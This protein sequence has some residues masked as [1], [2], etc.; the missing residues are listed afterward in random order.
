M[1][2]ILSKSDLS[3]LLSIE[4]AV[5][6]VPW[7]EETF[8]ACFDAGCFGFALEDDQQMV[9][10]IFASIRHHECHILNL[11]VAH[12]YQKRGYGR[13]LLEELLKAAKQQGVGIAYLEVRRSNTRAILLY[14][15]MDF[16]FVGERKGYYPMP[17]GN[18]DALVFAKSLRE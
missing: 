5:H 4:R 11:C 16:Y 17:T 7:S 2:R 8:I 6:I 1:I 10:F 3:A 14:Q 9:G 12:T 15:K 13:K 18:E